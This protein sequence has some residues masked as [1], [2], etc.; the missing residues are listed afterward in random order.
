MPSQILAAHGG[1]PVWVFAYGSLLWIPAQPGLP[2]RIVTANGWHR[3]FCL[4]MRCWRGSP[5]QPG[6][7][8]ALK[9]GGSCTGIAVKL[10]DID[11]HNHLVKLLRREIGGQEG[12]K[13]LRSIDLVS[14]DGPAKALSF[15][16]NPPEV[17]A[18][19]ERS[20]MKV[21]QI[22]SRA[23][24]HIGSGA[25]YLFRTVEALENL[26]IRDPYLWRVQELV[27][28]EISGRNLHEK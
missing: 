27:A 11:R 23:C 20:K 1:D 19:P 7:M 8:L 3:S 26:G 18:K 28:A 6:L 24:G 5:D 12:L 4:E 21:A 14:D 17:A 10:P 15:Y 9:T 22:L 25:E 2:W 16:T 13:S